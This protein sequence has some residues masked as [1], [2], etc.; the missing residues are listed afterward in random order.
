MNYDSY[1][2]YRVGQVYQE[3]REK[4]DS[5]ILLS[6][7]IAGCTKFSTRLAKGKPM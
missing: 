2:C 5:A 6:T 4:R 7:G 3:N 1:N